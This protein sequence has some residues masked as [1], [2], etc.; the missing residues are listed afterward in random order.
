[1]SFHQEERDI[2]TGRCCG[3]LLARILSEEAEQ[4]EY[5]ASGSD[6]RAA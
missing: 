5:K 3:D 1:M 4:D 6:C 2:G